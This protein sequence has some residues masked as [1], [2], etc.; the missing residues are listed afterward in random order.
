MAGDHCQ[1]TTI[2]QEADKFAPT[3]TVKSNMLA[4]VGFVDFA[5]NLGDFPNHQEQV[6]PHLSRYTAAMISSP[7]W[8]CFPQVLFDDFF[9]D[10][11]YV[12]G[13]KSEP[14]SHP[15]ASLHIQGLQ[16]ADGD[17]NAEVDDPMANK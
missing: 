10:V 13:Q 4:P 11:K 3:V 16:H 1:R 7:L 14:A 5:R 15:P 17:A 8:K 12:A 6:F 9:A 2:E